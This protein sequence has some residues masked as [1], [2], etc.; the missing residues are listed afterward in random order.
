MEP[1]PLR[2]H[3]DDAGQATVEKGTGDADLK[4]PVQAL[5]AA[6]LGGG[7]LVAQHRAGLLVEQRPG[8][9]TELSFA[10]RT[11]VAPSGAMGF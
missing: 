5:G 6:Y 8:A 7:N 2:I 10:M 11:P 3:V 9:A 1:R 4:L